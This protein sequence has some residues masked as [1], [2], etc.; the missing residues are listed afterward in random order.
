MVPFTVEHPTSA[1][2]MDTVFCCTQTSGMI[3]SE[4]LFEIPV[5]NSFKEE[6][7][8]IKM[9]IV[10]HSFTIQFNFLLPKTIS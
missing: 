3:S 2:R 6:C 7:D 10:P 4:S 1:T 8:T 9:H 5:S